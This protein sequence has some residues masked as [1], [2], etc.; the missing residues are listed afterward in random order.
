MLIF[1]M[2]I[3]PLSNPSLQKVSYV[4]FN[5]EG[6]ISVHISE[7][8]FKRYKEQLTFDQLCASL[9]DVFKRFLEYYKKGNEARI[10][11]ELKS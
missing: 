3:S 4:S 2:G 6:K 8:D 1:S 9:G 7:H 11:I 5:S 10:G